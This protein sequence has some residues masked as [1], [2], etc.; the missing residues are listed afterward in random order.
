MEITFYNA[1][2]PRRLLNKGF[3]SLADVAPIL[4][5]NGE[6]VTIDAQGEVEY[7]NII[8]VYRD[9]KL[10]G[11][12][13]TCLELHGQITLTLDHA[14][15]TNTEASLT[16]IKIADDFTGNIK[17]IDSAVHC[18]SSVN[19]GYAINSD[20][21]DFSTR[22]NSIILQ[23]ATIDGLAIMPI[24]LTM[25][26]EI[27]INSNSQD[28]YSAINASLIEASSAR[29]CA[30]YLTIIN[31]NSEPCK[32]LELECDAGPVQVSGNW[33]I[34]TLIV[35]S[36]DSM[37]LFR[38]IGTNIP[39]AISI[40]TLT[41][42]KASKGISAFYAEKASV[43]FENATLGDPKSQTNVAVKDSDIYM[44]NT[45]DYL[46]WTATGTNGLQLDGNS[47]TKLRM[48]KN[49]FK[50]V[51]NIESSENESSESKESNKSNNNLNDLDISDDDDDDTDQETSNSNTIAEKPG[52]KGLANAQA[53]K[54]EIK[55]NE[56]HKDVEK[57][58]GMTQLNNLIGL[59]SVKKTL[60]KFI[61]IAVMNKR[62]AKRGLK[63]TTDLSRHMVMA[64][65]PGT[66]KTTVAE[67]VSQILYEEGALRTNKCVEVTSKDVISDHIGGTA[68]AMDKAVQDALGGVLFIDEAY[69]L[70]STQ[71]DNKFAQDAADTLM[72]DMEKY[73]NDLIVILAGY[74]KPMRDFLENANPG[75]S[76]RF[77][78]WVHFPDYSQ[79]EELQILQLMLKKQG[80]LINPQY[81]HTKM[82]L[83]NLKFYN[84]DHANGRSVRNYYQALASAKASRLVKIDPAKLTDEQLMTI[85]AADIKT[86]YKES[87]KTLKYEK[88]QQD[89]K[90]SR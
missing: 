53:N 45:K 69:M 11:K 17:I 61:D 90:K 71:N 68:K 38:F 16:T 57:A 22:P 35:N 50:A 54:T 29:L 73:H 42:L 77:T 75:L 72:R 4:S 27:H 40:K 41:I 36:R 5:Q 59:S 51:G 46:I 79:E 49:Q 44:S 13:K 74:E 65:N 23:N 67:I 21:G 33:L 52:D 55:D 48:M 47:L 37:E 76:S 26:G 1:L 28:S 82:F 70:D 81:L 63:Q 10:T 39:T 15:L 8:P 83:W 18:K 88:K 3:K 31:A 9:V 58:N 84:R 64:G 78:Y 30:K 89:E 86:V 32:I 6:G 25:R 66:G 87:I 34:G 62:L 85:E 14:N 12:L 19:T 80:I 7:D 43:S 2:D 56:S 20:V 60:Q 24:S